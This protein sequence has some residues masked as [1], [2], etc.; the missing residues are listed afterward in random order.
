MREEAAD[1]EDKRGRVREG[2][3][4]IC[5]EEEEKKGRHVD[6]MKDSQPK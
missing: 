4:E 2:G 5:G 6:R 1:D 3:R